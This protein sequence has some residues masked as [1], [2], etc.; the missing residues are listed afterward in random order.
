MRITCPSCTSHFEIPTELLGKKGRA[1]KCASCGHSWYQAAHVEDLD[2]A[3]IMGDDYAQ[4][5]ANTG[6]NAGVQ[7][8]NEMTSASVALA[9]QQAQQ[10]A[11]RA[12]SQQAA[13]QRTQEAAAQRAQ[14]A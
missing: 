5:A 1:L 9:Q 3:A 14:A 11:R 10:A 6:A 4:Q 13:A 7:I 12:A 2:L 8:R